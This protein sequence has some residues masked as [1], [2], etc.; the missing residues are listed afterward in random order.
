V[1]LGSKSKGLR[2]QFF[3]EEKNQKTFIF[4]ATPYVGGRGRNLMPAQAQKSL[5]LFF[6]KRTFPTLRR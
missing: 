2:K 4:G 1:D 5:V 6:R 3:S